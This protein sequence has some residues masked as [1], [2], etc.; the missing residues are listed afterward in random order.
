MDATDPVISRIE[1]ITD[2]LAGEAVDEFKADD[3][4]KLV[5][6]IMRNYQDLDDSTK[7][8]LLKLF[9][10]TSQAPDDTMP[11]KTNESVKTRAS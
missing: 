10:Q 11:C 7:Q 1:S 8:Q 9:M 2:R 3:Q 4:D 5:K 6:Q